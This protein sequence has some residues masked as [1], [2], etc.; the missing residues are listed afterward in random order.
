MS[1][2]LIGIIVAVALEA[3]VLIFMAGRTFEHEK[4]SREM[5]TEV[6][7]S[8]KAETKRVEGVSNERI[9]RMEA[10]LEMCE[11]TTK[12]DIRIIQKQTL[13]QFGAINQKIT[14]ILQNT[15]SINERL[16]S[17]PCKSHSDI[18]LENRERIARLEVASSMNGGGG[19]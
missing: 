12:E 9:D 11:R 14:E 1:D 15:S 2:A 8:C 7:D 18:L 16:S 4:A 3:V 17:L 5:I 10:S 19:K 6:S 13:D